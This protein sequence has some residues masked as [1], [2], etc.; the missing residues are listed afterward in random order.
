MNTD[1]RPRLADSSDLWIAAAISVV[2]TLGLMGL[3]KIFLG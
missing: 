1:H 2:A 3:L